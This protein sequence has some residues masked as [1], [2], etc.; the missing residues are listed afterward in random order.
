MSEEETLKQLNF[1]YIQII[2]NV[3]FNLNLIEKMGRM[4][5]CLHFSYFLIHSSFVFSVY[6]NTQ[7]IILILIIW[8]VCVGTSSW[9]PSQSI[10]NMWTTSWITKEPLSKSPHYL[11]VG[12]WFY[13]TS[14]FFIHLVK[15]S[16]LFNNKRF[17]LKYYILINSYPKLK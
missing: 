15:L 9:M 4:C 14:L 5:Y 1:V 3:D 7:I 17:I 10:D 12:H 2:Q 11:P 6:V 8:Y 16:Y 13:K